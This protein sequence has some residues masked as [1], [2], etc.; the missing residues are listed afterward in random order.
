MTIQRVFG[1]F[2][3]IRGSSLP[4][5]SLCVVYIPVASEKEEATTIHTHPSPTPKN[6]PAEPSVPQ[7]IQVVLPPKE[8]SPASAS[9][10][11]VRRGSADKS[12]NSAP[13]GGVKTPES[14]SPNPTPGDV[15][16]WEPAVVAQT[17]VYS[18]KNDSALPKSRLSNLKSAIPQAHP[19]A[20]QV[21]ATSTK[22]EQHFQTE[23]AHSISGYTKT[24]DVN[25]QS[26]DTESS[27]RL[28]AEVATKVPVGGVRTLSTSQAPAYPSDRTNPHLALSGPLLGAEVTVQRPL[29]PT[30]QASSVTSREI[31]TSPTSQFKPEVNFPAVAVI[32]NSVVSADLQSQATADHDTVGGAGANQLKRPHQPSQL[33][34]LP[35]TQTAAVFNAARKSPV[36]MGPEGE[37]PSTQTSKFVTA[38]LTLNTT[39]GWQPSP[40][41]VANY[42]IDEYEEDEKVLR[43]VHEPVNHDDHYQGLC[44]S[45]RY[46]TG[47]EMARYFLGSCSIQFSTDKANAIFTALKGTYLMPY[48]SRTTTILDRYQLRLI[49]HDGQMRF[50][51]AKHILALFLRRNIFDLLVFGLSEAESSCMHAVVD[52][53]L[54]G[55]MVFHDKACREGEISMK[56]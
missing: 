52:Q 41:L 22:P 21:E 32:G 25:L 23:R 17:A 27:L 11:N 49:H 36:Q 9:I 50:A 6:N 35:V 16:A 54:T 55:K 34:D 56:V 31:Q 40:D 7:P 38:P 8:F 14:S 53:A 15:K 26:S 39:R 4:A 30:T 45:L 43:I 20:V 46:L 3:P 33:V 42:A 1:L 48:G 47:T 28:T 12:N 18:S 51:F 19:A 13:L 5:P 10:V 29:H 2:V 44:D 37:L 24:P